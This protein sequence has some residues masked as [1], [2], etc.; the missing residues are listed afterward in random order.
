MFV[1]WQLGLS[2]S[3]TMRNIAK[4][5]GQHAPLGKGHKEKQATPILFTRPVLIMYQTLWNTI[6][7]NIT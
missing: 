2:A 6:Y 5:C 7:K 1:L 3:S 4:H